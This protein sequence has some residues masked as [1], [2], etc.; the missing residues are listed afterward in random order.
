MKLPSQPV[1]VTRILDQY[2][3][4][5][6]VSKLKYHTAEEVRIVNHDYI[7]TLIGKERLTLKYMPQVL[8]SFLKVLS[9]DISKKDCQPEEYQEI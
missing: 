1:F 2:K 9:S 5:R 7:N 6:L 3:F 4:H 8:A